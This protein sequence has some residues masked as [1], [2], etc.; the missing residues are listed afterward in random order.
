[1][2]AASAGQSGA[3]LTTNFVPSDRLNGTRIKVSN[4]QRDPAFPG[5]FGIFIEF[6]V[7]AGDLLM[8]EAIQEGGAWAWQTIAENPPLTGLSH[9]TAGIGWALLEM[10]QA[11]GETRFR[12]AAQGAFAYERACLGSRSGWTGRS[13]SGRMGRSDMRVRARC[14]RAGCCART[15]LPRRVGRRK[16][17]PHFTWRAWRRWRNWR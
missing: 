13:A 12:E 9:G 8:K 3:E 17:L 14:G 6:R 15:R 4:S 1:M 11:T 7:K 16:R 2:A 5:L 10:W